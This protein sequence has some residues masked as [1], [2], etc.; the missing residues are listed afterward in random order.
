MAGKDEAAFVNREF[1]IVKG[2]VKNGPAFYF[3]NFTL[4]YPLVGPRYHT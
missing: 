3:S 4:F 2:R 1:L